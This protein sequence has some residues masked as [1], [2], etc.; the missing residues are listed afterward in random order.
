MQAIKNGNAVL[1]ENIWPDGYK[2]DRTLLGKEVVNVDDSTDVYKI[3]AVSTKVRYND[4]GQITAIAI[5]L[6]LLRKH[7][8]PRLM[9]TCIRSIRKFACV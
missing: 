9:M 7:N 5:W 6:F 4:F 3:A 8:W 1:S 2:G